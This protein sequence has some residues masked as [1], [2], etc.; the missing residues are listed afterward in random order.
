LTLPHPVR[1]RL[2]TPSIHLTAAVCLAVVTGLLAYRSLD[3]MAAGARRYGDPVEVLVARTDL[4]PGDRLDDRSV[5]LRR[6]PSAAVAP[7][8]LRSR[9]RTRV[10]RRAVSAGEVLV[11]GDLTAPGTSPLAAALPPGSVAVAV[12]RGDAAL[13]VAR[14]DHVD[15]LAAVGDGGGDLLPVA[16]DATVVATARMTITVAVAPDE[17]GRVAAAVAAGLVVPAI[18]G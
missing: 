7:T 3:A 13:D 9:S 8:A 6:L 11:A 17:V 1:R 18:R 12:P 14:G 10:L 2:R 5:E 16:R 4:D 15:L